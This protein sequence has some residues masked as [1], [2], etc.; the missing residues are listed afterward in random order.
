M[1]AGRPLAVAASRFHA[2]SNASQAR[3]R[4]LHPEGRGR[5]A[6]FRALIPCNTPMHFTSSSCS[7]AGKVSL[8]VP[9]NTASLVAVVAG[10]QL[11]FF[12]DL[13]RAFVT[14]LTSPGT[15]T[16]THTQHHTLPLPAAAHALPPRRQAQ[17]LQ[18][19]AAPPPRRASPRARA[20]PFPRTRPSSRGLPPRLSSLRGSPLA[21]CA[22]C[23]RPRGPPRRGRPF[24]RTAARTRAPSRCCASTAT[25]AAW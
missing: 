6:L 5:L 25:A 17:P 20:P 22:R 4:R 13:V 11:S 9:A 24:P 8:C 18:R 23:A 1:R 14:S 19:P 7:G 16:H 10:P 12:S 21:P 3:P 15:H 2:S